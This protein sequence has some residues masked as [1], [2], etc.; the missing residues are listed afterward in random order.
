MLP[1]TARPVHTEELEQRLQIMETT[2]QLQQKD[3][4]QAR[5]IKDELVAQ[6]EQKE[7]RLREAEQRLI[8]EVE[9]HER[10]QRELIRARHD[11]DCAVVTNERLE[12]EH[13]TQRDRDEAGVEQWT[14]RC[15]QMTQRC[16]QMTQRCAELERI[17][18]ELQEKVQH[19]DNLKST[20]EAQADERHRELTNLLALASEASRRLDGEKRMLEVELEKVKN[21]QR[22]V[23]QETRELRCRTAVLED[24][25][26]DAQEQR[27]R[28]E[29]DQQRAEQDLRQW[30]QKFIESNKEN[31]VL[32][33][34]NQDHKRDIWDLESQLRQER[35]AAN[36]AKPGEYLKLMK[37]HEGESLATDNGRLKKALN[38]TQ[39]DLDLCIRKLHE[40]ERLI[41]ANT[42]NA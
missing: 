37:A 42:P 24:Q 20:A 34:A 11:Y 14:Q 27:Q 26:R 30:Y 28:T 9:Q 15:Q 35:N 31:T 18:Q 22:E 36:V 2:V 4:Q 38:K 8:H 25:L 32:Q 41:K 7:L 16:E 40:Q 5:E 19:A 39:C 29:N 33:R 23:E 12:M 3:V 10:T 21:Q 1:Q 13:R 17:E 6:L